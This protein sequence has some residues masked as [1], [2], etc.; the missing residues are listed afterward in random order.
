M[1]REVR[2]TSSSVV[3]EEVEERVRGKLL[4]LPKSRPYASKLVLTQR[5]KV[6]PQE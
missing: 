2:R 6:V 5:S 3:A 1:K 4:C